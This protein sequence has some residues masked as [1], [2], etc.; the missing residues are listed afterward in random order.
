WREFSIQPR[1]ITTPP[2]AAG[3]QTG[4]AVL[5]ANFPAR[6]FHWL[7][8][9]CGKFRCDVAVRGRSCAAVKPSFGGRRSTTPQLK[10]KI[11]GLAELA[12]PKFALPL[13]HS[14]P[15]NPISR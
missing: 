11:Q 4:R 8:P 13:P 9:A 7:A 10:V 6:I 12:P 2:A 14:S 5:S 3:G 15:E 1:A